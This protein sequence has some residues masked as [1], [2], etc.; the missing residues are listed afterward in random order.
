MIEIALRLFCAV[1]AFAAIAQAASSAR[2]ED[3][4]C[5]APA[6]IG[7][8]AR[9]ESYRPVFEQCRNEAKDIRLAIRRFAASGDERL[10]VVHPET[11]ATSLEP[12]RCWRCEETTDA[13]QA[14]TRYLRALRPAPASPRPAP[15]VNAGLIHGAGEGVFVTGDLCPSRKPLDRAFF[16]RLAAQQPGAPV[17]LAV[18]GY[19]LL[20]HK[21]DF[22]WLTQKHAA[23][24]LAVSWANHSY[25]HP[26]LPG[27]GDAGNYLLRPGTDMDREIFETE[28]LLIANGAT[29]SV[30]FRFPG[31]VADAALLEKL[32]ERHLVALGADSWLALGP[33]PRAGSIVL[34][35]P[36]GNEPAGL[37]LFSRLLD[38]GRLP[39]PFRP[40]ND[41]PQP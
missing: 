40:L 28:R 17:A 30:F 36:N 6:K 24:A 4:A 14:Q 39:Q 15:L 18:S 34:V 16:E 7:G 31:L 5:A 37:R 2:A 21:A 29:P 32:R 12:A 41:A 27:L 10:L 9:I 1:S 13:E 11:L 33:P 20:R 25:R 38:R 23:G 8:A 3:A 26:Y 22:E 35:H 19:W